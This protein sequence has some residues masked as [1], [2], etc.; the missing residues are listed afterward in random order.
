LDVFRNVTLPMMSPVILFQVILGLIGAFQ[1]F[2]VPLL[3][4]G[5]GNMSA[6]VTRSLYLY[7]IHTYQEIFVNQ[8]FGYG[9]AL[10]WMLFIFIVVVTFVVF[11]TS[12]YW[13]YEE[14]G[15][16]GAA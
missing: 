2:V 8:R 13:V 6:T 12:R 15:P 10:L 11:R 5:Q 3:M 7:M 14:V 1:A 16:R 4:Y 9:A